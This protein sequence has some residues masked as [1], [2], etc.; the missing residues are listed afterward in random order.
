MWMRIRFRIA[1]GTE[2][3]GYRGGAGV[4]RPEPAADVQ[5]PA[6]AARRAPWRATPSWRVSTATRQAGPAGGY[7]Q[8]RGRPGRPRVRRHPGTRRRR[9]PLQPGAARAWASCRPRCRGR[10]CSTASCGTRSA[11]PWTSGSAWRPTYCIGNAAGGNWSAHGDGAGLAAVIVA[12]SGGADRPDCRWRK[13]AADR[14]RAAGRHRR[15]RP[16]EQVQARLQDAARLEATLDGSG[17]GDGAHG[18]PCGDRPP[19]QLRRQDTRA[20]RGTGPRTTAGSRSAAASTRSPTRTR[21]GATP[22]RGEIAQGVLVPVPRSRRVDRRGLQ[23]LLRPADQRCPAGRRGQ[24]R[25][26]LV[27]RQRRPGHRGGKGRRQGRARRCRPRA[28][29]PGTRRPASAQ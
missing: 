26:S 8:R 29:D 12:A 23:R 21:G 25:R 14:R 13:R 7:L 18:R 11:T 20:T 10:T 1:I 2:T 17:P 24:R 15:P 16:P 28:R 22:R 5:R 27:R 9:R 6:G 4:G 19:R 3:S